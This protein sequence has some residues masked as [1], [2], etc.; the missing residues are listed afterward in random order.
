MSTLKISSIFL[1]TFLLFSNITDGQ[2]NDSKIDSIGYLF[3]PVIVDA[4]FPG[5]TKA[6]N[7]FLSKNLNTHI[8]KEKGCPSGR[9]HTL[10]FFWINKEG[11]IDTII[12][13][14]HF[15]YGMEEEVARVIKLS[16]KWIPATRS[17]RLIK[18]MKRL[19]I[20][21]VVVNEKEEKKN[22]N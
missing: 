11:Y 5:G 22:N 8:A 15:G 10:S 16:P 18:D 13:K 19:P 7:D 9:Y 14:T 2:S 17:G 20:T 4:E 6:W 1:L 12:R 3:E 21:F